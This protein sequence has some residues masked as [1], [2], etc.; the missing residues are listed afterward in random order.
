MCIFKKKPE[1]KPVIRPMIRKEVDFNYIFNIINTK[2]PNAPHIYLSDSTYYLC[3]EDDI[4]SF[5]DMD[6][7]NKETYI[8]E[9]FD[10]DDFSYRLIGQLSVPEWSGIAFGIVW[11]DLHALNCFIDTNGKFWFIEPQT[12]AIQEILDDWQG[13]D[14]QFVMM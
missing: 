14:I 6:S 10:C 7:T 1:F 3:S 2:L 9:E 11:T 5:L 4:K 8:A 13:K 12:D